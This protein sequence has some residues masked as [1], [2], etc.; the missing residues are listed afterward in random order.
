MI[1]VDVTQIGDIAIGDE[2]I[3]WGDEK[4]TI[5]DVAENANTISY[6]LLCQVN[7]RVIRDY[8]NGKN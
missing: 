2:V 4:L 7:Q 5:D 6:E 3:I 8:R 1:A